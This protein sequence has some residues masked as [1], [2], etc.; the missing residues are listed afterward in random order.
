METTNTNFNTANPLQGKP[1]ITRTDINTEAEARPQI[2]KATDL[3]SFMVGNTAKNRS[4]NPVENKEQFIAS[5][6]SGSEAWGGA[7]SPEATT[8]SSS[9][10]IAH[11][12]GE[13]TQDF[14]EDLI[15]EDT[16]EQQTKETSPKLETPEV[17]E[18]A[19][20]IEVEDP[21]SDF[22]FS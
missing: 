11:E 7:T 12:A 19:T 1:V 6:E 16:R 10:T 2:N 20:D 13:I 21:W 15:E 18:L 4:S 14:T 22:S 17:P 5:T 9:E 3:L 8:N